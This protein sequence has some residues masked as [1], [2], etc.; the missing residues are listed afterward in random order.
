MLPIVYGYPSFELFEASR[1]GDIALGGC[2]IRRGHPTHR[3]TACGEDVIPEFDADTMTVA[4]CA[5][6]G[7]PLDGDP[8]DEP[9]GDAGM[10]ICGECNR[11]RNFAA[12]EEAELLDVP[13]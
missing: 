2:V 10:P 7:R 3:C 11:E 13:E 6:C 5:T 12:I 4:A 8:E 1:L 9:A